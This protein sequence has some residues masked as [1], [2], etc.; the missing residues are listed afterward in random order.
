[1]NYIIL[2]KNCISTILEDHFIF[3]LII[4]HITNPK[5]NKMK[6]ISFYLMMMVL[7]LTFVPTTTFAA[8]KNLTTVTSNTKEIPENVKKMLSRLDEIKAM[9]KSSM[10]SSEK[11]AL[12]KEVRAI[13]AELRSTGNG[14]YLSV[15]AIIIVIL[16]LIL[17]L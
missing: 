5:K 2:S 11:K 13:N 6:K 4:K 16:L 14:V 10:K 1:M 8:E 15:G 7:S 17:L 9:D 12:R 3:T